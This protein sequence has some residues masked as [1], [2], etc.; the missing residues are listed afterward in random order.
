MT[1]PLRVLHVITRLVKG[2]AQQVVLDLIAGLRAPDLDIQL[3]ALGDHA[4]PFSARLLVPP[5]S[6]MM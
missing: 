1:T 4:H 3:V 6:P 5:S 2:G